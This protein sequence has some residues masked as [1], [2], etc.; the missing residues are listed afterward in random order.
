MYEFTDLYTISREKWE[1]MGVL[2]GISKTLKRDMK[3]YQRFLY[4]FSGVK[5]GSNIKTEI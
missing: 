4:D 1:E 5:M 3:E 2:G